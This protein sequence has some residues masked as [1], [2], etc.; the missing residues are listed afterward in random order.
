[1]QR[2]E[3]IKQFSKGIVQD[4]GID[5]HLGKL[6][7]GVGLL[8]THRVLFSKQTR[9]NEPVIRSLD[10]QIDLH[11]VIEGKKVIFNY[12]LKDLNQSLKDL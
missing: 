5:V 11:L 12:K 7:R 6:F 9:S 1:L 10:N 4:P 2:S 3:D 8:S